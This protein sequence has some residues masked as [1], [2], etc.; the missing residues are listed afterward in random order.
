MYTQ[1]DLASR[2]SGIRVS[3]LNW[4]DISPLYFKKMLDGKIAESSSK[5]AELGTQL[6]MYI[7]EHDK[8]KKAYLYE[9]FDKP[10]GDKQKEFCEACAALKKNNDS[11]NDIEIAIP[12]YKAVYTIDKKSDEKIK[13]EALTLYKTMYDYI[14]Y[15]SIQSKYE[16]IIGHS[17]YTFLSAAKYVIEKHTLAN[18]LLLA[19]NDSFIDDPNTFVE[20]ELMLY[21]EYPGLE[22]KG[23]PLV[24]RSTIDRLKID[25][26]TKTIQLIDIKTCNRLYEFKDKVIERSYN[27]QMACYWKAIEYYFT[28]K[29]PELDFKEFK[30]E[31]YL[32]GI[33]TPNIYINLPTECKVTALSNETLEAGAEDLEKKLRAIL[34]HFN[35]NLWDHSIFHYLHNGIDLVV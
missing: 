2:Y 11:L 24:L 3:S 23:T 18:E 12:A 31:T 20:N 15:L 30:Q 19:G 34:W 4:F 1:E 27:R 33:Q 13:E 9:N 26:K 6:H 7:L 10:R 5:E 25:F 17:S 29:W 32:V 14:N 8:F 16:G 21:W 35:N 28:N 22:F